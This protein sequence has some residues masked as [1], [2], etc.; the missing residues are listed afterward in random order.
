MIYCM[1]TRI[2]FSVNNTD[3]L[4]TR[5]VTDFLLYPEFSNFRMFVFTRNITDSHGFSFLFFLSRIFE[6][7][8]WTHWPTGGNF[9]IFVFRDSPWFPVWLK[10]NSL[11]RKFVTKIIPWF[12][13][14]LRVTIRKFENSLIR[15]RERLFRDTPRFSVWLKRNNSLIRKFVTRKI[16]TCEKPPWCI[17]RTPDGTTLVIYSLYI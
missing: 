5:I 11:I 2:F 15:D 13:A 3:Y 16:I 1:R 10:I 7:C 12:S 4:F 17:I 6:T 9:R 14:I 8:P